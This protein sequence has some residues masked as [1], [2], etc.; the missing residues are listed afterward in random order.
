MARKTR[1]ENPVGFY[2]FI[3]R[4]VNKRKLFHQDKDFKKYLELVREYRDLLGIHIYHYCLMNNH[5]HILLKAGT[6]SALSQFGHFTHRRYA[7]YYCRTY[8]L[9]GQVF[10][11]NFV[12][13]PIARDNY[14]LECGR[15]IERNPLKAKL[16]KNLEDYPYSSY[17]HYVEGKNDP[18]VTESPLFLTLAHTP[19]ERKAVYRFYVTH[20]REQEMKT[21]P[22]T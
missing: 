5:V 12:S 3:T 7:Y 17:A 14:L 18:L 15:Y 22:Q 10:R 21:G 13:L 2:H 9:S 6:M 1:R 11:R 16:V 20:T 8:D 4:G 19:L